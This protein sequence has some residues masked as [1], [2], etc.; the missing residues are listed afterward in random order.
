M[1]VVAGT[2]AADPAVYIEVVDDPVEGVPQPAPRELRSSTGEIV[3][4]LEAAGE[5]VVAACQAVIGK[6]RT[7]LA[8][9]APDELELEFGVVL[10]GEAGIPVLTK[11]SAEA[12]LKVK[13]TWSARVRRDE[14]GL[15]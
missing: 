2:S 9:A 11:A 3:G 4:R 13:A 14:Q 1:R 10:A 8:D 15:V 5:A 12:T 6:V 7:D